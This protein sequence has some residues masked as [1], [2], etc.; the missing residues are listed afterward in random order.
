LEWI[1]VHI[2]FSLLTADP[3]YVQ[4]LNPLKFKIA[5]C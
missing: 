5:Q 1:S 3:R 4:Q 2:L